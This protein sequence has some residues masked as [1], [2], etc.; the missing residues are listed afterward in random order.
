MKS[1]RPAE[2]GKPTMK[3]KNTTVVFKE[4][5]RNQLL[6]IIGTLS[7]IGFYQGNVLVFSQFT[8]LIGI[9]PEGY[10]WSVEIVED[11]SNVLAGHLVTNAK[12]IFA[13]RKAAFGRRK[14]KAR[15]CAKAETKEFNDI[16]KNARR[17]LQAHMDSA[18]P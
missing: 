4:K 11:S 16:L 2:F 14:V 9:P 7:V 10:T 12:A 17:T 15:Q 6:Q 13:E 18:M 1:G 8:L 5:R 3:K